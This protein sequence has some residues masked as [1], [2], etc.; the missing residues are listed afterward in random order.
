MPFYSALSPTLPFRDSVRLKLAGIA[1][2]LFLASLVIPPG[3]VARGIS[4]GVGFGF[5]GQP[6]ITRGIHWLN[7]NVP[8]WPQYLELRK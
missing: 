8:N 5:F 6:L 4:F 3:L 1:S 7:V 2:G